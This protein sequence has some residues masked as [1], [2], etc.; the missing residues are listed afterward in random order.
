MQKNDSLIKKNK[1]LE[2]QLKIF[3]DDEEMAGEEDIF[4]NGE[5]NK[6][7]F[8]CIFIIYI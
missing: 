2:N 7:V 1:K 5:I 3:D 4:K 6:V 8:H